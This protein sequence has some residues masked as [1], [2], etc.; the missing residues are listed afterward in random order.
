MCKLKAAC[1]INVLQA[2]LCKPAQ[3]YLVSSQLLAASLCC[4]HRQRKCKFL[5]DQTVA[6]TLAAQAVPA[7]G[8]MQEYTHVSLLAPNPVCCRWQ[9][10]L[11]HQAVQLVGQEDEDDLYFESGQHSQEFLKLMV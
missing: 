1:C 10:R 7:N 2:L 4:A 3:L 8:L 9:S 6:I 5:D 11:A